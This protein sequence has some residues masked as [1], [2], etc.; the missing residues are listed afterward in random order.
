MAADCLAVY[1][2]L[3]AQRRPDQ[4]IISGDS[5]GGNLAFGMLTAARD[6]GLPMPAG[7]IA[8]SAWLDLGYRHPRS[9]PRDAFFALRFAR[10]A[11]ALCS[12][13]NGPRPEVRPLELDLQGLPPTLMQIGSTEPLVPGNRQMA[14]TLAAA[15]VPVELQLWENQVHVFQAFAAV[16]PEGRAAIAEIAGFVDGATSSAR[17]MTG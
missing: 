15:G 2:W 10:R 16:L 3:V 4:L 5:A 8:V 1:R 6:Q 7:L 13:D 17:G 12:D 11:A 14:A 9:A